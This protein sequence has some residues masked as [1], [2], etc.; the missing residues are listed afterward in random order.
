[1]TKLL[2]LAF[3]KAA[4]LPDA[5]QELLASRLLTELEDETAF[6]AAITQSG[7]KLAQLAEAALREHRAGKTRI[8][9]P[10]QL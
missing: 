6:D 9:D 2:E 1:M 3:A 8:L 5:E 10:D 4:K 7:D